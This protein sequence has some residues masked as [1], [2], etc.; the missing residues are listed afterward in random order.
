MAFAETGYNLTGQFLSFWRASGGVPVLGYPISPIRAANGAV[1]QWFER[2]QLEWHP[3][4]AAPYTLELARVGVEALAQ[5]GIDRLDLPSV[6]TAASG[7]RYFGVTHHTL[8]GDFLRTGA[9]MVSGW[10]IV[11]SVSVSPWHSSVI[12][13]PSHKW[14]APRR[15]IQF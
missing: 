9:A 8:C 14:S 11:A 6:D 13:S 12:R 15:A 7:C 10:K 3:D 1:S 4:N 2:G 5:E